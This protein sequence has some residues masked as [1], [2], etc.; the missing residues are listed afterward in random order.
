MDNKYLTTIEVARHFQV[1][2][3]TILNWRLVGM[4]FIRMGEK[5][6]RYDL[7]EVTAWAKEY[8]KDQTAL[9]SKLPMGA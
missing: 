2:R 3:Q 9:S 1:T 8:T 4:P 7:A 6:F 5:T